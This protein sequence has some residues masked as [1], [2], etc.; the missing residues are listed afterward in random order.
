SASVVAAL[1]VTSAAI[2][3]G[4]S[5]HRQIRKSSAAQLTAT[6]ALALSSVPVEV[7]GALPL[8]SIAWAGFA[9]VVVFVTS[10]LV[11]RASFARAARG[12]QL[13]SVLLYG[14][15]LVIP[16]LSAALLFALGRGAEAGTCVIAGGV[17]AVFA[18][19]RPTVKQLKPLGLVLAGLA[20]S[21]AVTLAL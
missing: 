4:S 5:S 2:A 14:A 9:R 1:L 10:A 11:V 8:A 13:R 21:T 15:T 6:A 16:A 19:A 12:G 18:W 17:C 20:L 3:A 7:A